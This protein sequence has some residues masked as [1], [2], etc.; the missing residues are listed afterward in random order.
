M[1]AKPVGEEV[2]IAEPA[3]PLIEGQDEQVAPFELF[4]DLLPISRPG[5]GVAQRCAQALEDGGVDQERPEPI[6]QRGDD[7]VAEVVEDVSMIRGE[8]VDDRGGVVADTGRQADELDR[9]HPPL[10]AL[11][12]SLCVEGWQRDAGDPPEHGRRLVGVEPQLVEAQLAQRPVR[13]QPRQRQRR[14]VTG[15]D[16]QPQR[17]RCLDEE[18]VDTGMDDGIA[19]DVVVVEHH[20][21]RSARLLDE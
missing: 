12:E 2:V 1:E 6:G 19:D 13:A 21:D 4:Q 15:G 11:D 16:H 9:R 18:L 17:R 10:G 20:D 7:L 3:A 5:D 8:G 14:V